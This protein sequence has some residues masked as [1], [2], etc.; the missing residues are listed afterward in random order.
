[1]TIWASLLGRLPTPGWIFNFN[2]VGYETKTGES[3]I[4]EVLSFQFLIHFPFGPLWFLREMF[5]YI[6]EPHRELL[7]GWGIWIRYPVYTTMQHVNTTQV[8][9]LSKLSHSL[10]FQRFDAYTS[11][12]IDPLYFSASLSKRP[13][14]VIEQPLMQ[15]PLMHL[16][17]NIPVKT[18]RIPPS[19]IKTNHK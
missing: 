17:Y 3:F 9:S 10:P 1:M 11:A 6:C 8:L 5:F 14:I 4:L 18:T 12:L 19:K 13:T 16:K 7:P 2:E 15:L